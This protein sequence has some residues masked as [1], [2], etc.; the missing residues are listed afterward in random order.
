MKRGSITGPLVLILVGSIFLLRAIQP[1]FEIGQLLGHYWPYLLILWGVVALLEVT[2]R[3]VSRAPVP[4]NGVSGGGWFLVVMVCIVGATAFEI[5]RPDTWWRQVGFTR[6]I[7]ALGDDHQ[8]SIDPQ[9]KVVGAAPH[10]IIESF[11]GDAKVTGGEGDEVTLSGQKSIRA[12]EGRDADAAD[13]QTAIDLIKDGDTVIV[14]C[15]QD[16]ANA[17]A[18]VTSNLE[19]TVPKGASVEAVG[20]RG[21]FDISNVAGDVSISSANAGV[22]LQDVGGRVKV[23][24]SRSDVIRCENVKGDVDLRGHGDD[25]ELY[26][27]AGQVTINGDYRGSVSLRELAQ[28]VRV[29]NSRTQ[30]AVQQIPG[31][32]RLDRGSFT[33]QNVIGPVTLSTHSTDVTFDGFSAGLDLTVDRGDVEIRPT[34]SPLGKIAVHS[35]SGNI[36]LALP[37]AAKFALNASTERGEIEND[38]GDSLKE[39]SQ[40]RGAKLEGSVGSGPDVD[41]VT[42]HGTIT[43]RKAAQEVKPVKASGK[44]DD[45]SKAALLEQTASAQ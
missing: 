18:T 34:G 38:F 17:R 4:A 36:E 39:S 42:N 26:K 23:E 31:E 11:R 30:L 19:L 21:D 5:Q 41:L 33:A 44:D 35:T 2:V 13:K 14:R 15:H 22:R 29:E 43:I 6:G 16:R 12:F 25:V 10:I 27:I 40:G 45:E 24:T 20:T 28:P 8:Y 32:V 37:A 9:K 1:G 3:F 7:E